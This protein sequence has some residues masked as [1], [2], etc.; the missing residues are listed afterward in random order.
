MSNARNEQ[1]FLSL[2]VPAYNEEKV[3]DVFHERTIP[4]LSSINDQFEII[5][6]NDGSSDCTAEKIK[7]L[8]LKDPRIKLIELSRNFGKEIALTAGLDFAQG[9]VVVVTDA[10]LQDPPELIPKMVEKWREGY[11]TV[12]AVRSI[13]E[14]ET[15]VK[16]ATANAFYRVIKRLSRVEIPENAGDFRLMSRRTVDALK[17]LREQHRFMKGIFSWIGFKQIGIPYSREPRIAGRTKWN[18]WRLFNFA[19]DGI[20]SFSYVP[21]QLS[22]YLG[23]FAA[24]FAFF[25]AG[26]LVLRTLVWG[27]DLPG[28]ASIMVA[29]LFFSGVQ[30]I[31]LG[32]IGEYLGRMF[33]ETKNRPLY[34]IQGMLGIDRLNEVDREMFSFDK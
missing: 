13:R 25:Y 14:G 6:V 26:Y 1:I 30:L 27:V 10:D 32:V 33:N 8:H 24:F 29:I 18:Y 16:K 19:V 3:I 12:Y 9:E 34:L 17:L 5:F 23:C 2:I 20:T 4:I 22:S 21:L 31:F 15:F 11:D 28:Y 7:A